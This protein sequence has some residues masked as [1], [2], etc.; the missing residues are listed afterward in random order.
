MN[1]LPPSAD[2]IHGKANGLVKV[3]RI[4]RDIRL[5]AHG[6]LQGADWTKAIDIRDL[7]S[8]AEQEMDLVEQK[9]IEEIKKQ[10][11]ICRGCKKQQQ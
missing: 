5:C 11:E 7:A 8:A 2:P 4:L 10:S 3:A 9:L 1:D 6:I